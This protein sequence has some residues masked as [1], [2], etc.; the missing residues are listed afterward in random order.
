MQVKLDL[1]D[2]QQSAFPA[3]LRPRVQRLVVRATSHEQLKDLSNRLSGV[4]SAAALE[5]EL[6]FGRK[7][8]INLGTVRTFFRRA[9]LTERVRAVK[10]SCRSVLGANLF[11]GSETP[12]S[13]ELWPSYTNSLP[14]GFWRNLFQHS[15][16][17]LQITVPDAEHPLH[18]L[19]S[20]LRCNERICGTLRCLQ[21]DVLARAPGRILTC[22]RMFEVTE[23]LAGLKLPCLTH[24]GFAGGIMFPWSSRDWPQKES[25]PM[26]QSFGGTKKPDG[27]FGLSMSGI[28]MDWEGAHMDWEGADF[29]GCM[30][31]LAGSALG[32]AIRELHV[33]MECMALSGSL[34]DAANS[35][36]CSALG[37]FAL[38]TSLQHLRIKG[39]RFGL[40]RIRA[41]AINALSGLQ[42]LALEH[43]TIEGYL[44]GPCLTQI[45]C[46]SLVTRLLTVLARPPPALTSVLV[47][48]RATDVVPK[49]VLGRNVSK[50]TEVTRACPGGPGWKISF[51]SCE[52]WDRHYQ[53]LRLFTRLLKAVPYRG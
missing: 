9:G 6:S 20:A 3:G 11:P 43:V 51:E 36:A 47:P 53:S 21:V 33:T 2:E 25:L 32:P 37:S 14:A 35:A 31:A 38:L 10:Y 4:P 13:A 26:L 52:L 24:L 34:L 16:V 27:I 28:H 40:L 8:V 22:L 45:V 42:T 30:A 1:A 19:K 39:E 29:C 48:H 12:V 17:E 15:L 5:L 7:G 46:L 49:T 44:T 50:W 41:D 23:F 18:G